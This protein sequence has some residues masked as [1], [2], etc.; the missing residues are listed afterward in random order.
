M[1]KNEMG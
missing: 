1:W